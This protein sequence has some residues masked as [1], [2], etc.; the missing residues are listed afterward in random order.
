MADT[1]DDRDAA[2][3]PWLEVTASRDFPSWLR[4]VTDG[5]SKTLMFGERKHED[6]EFDRLYPAFPLPEWCGW[7]WTSVPN[8]VGDNLGHTAVPINYMIPVGSSGSNDE[9]NNRLRP[10]EVIILV[11]RISAWRTVP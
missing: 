8:S 2:A 1:A 6:P 9:V 10:S 4:N 3:E 7:A 5:L 11:G